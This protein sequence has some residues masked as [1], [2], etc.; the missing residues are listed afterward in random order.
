MTDTE[1]ISHDPGRRNDIAKDALDIGMDDPYWLHNLSVDLYYHEGMDDL[2]R[3]AENLRE[4]AEALETAHEKVKDGEWTG[5]EAAVYLARRVTFGDYDVRSFLN[6][7]V[8]I[9]EEP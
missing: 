8:P 3:T 2:L 5:G 7:D 6:Q 4:D 1:S 9:A